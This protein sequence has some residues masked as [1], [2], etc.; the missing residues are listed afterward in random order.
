MNP[1]KSYP[2][3]IP[4][5]CLPP[6]QIKLSGFHEGFSRNN[7]RDQVHQPAEEDVHDEKFCDEG[8]NR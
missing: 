6:Q 3:N 8:V 2:C 7:T 4:F 1:F 5:Q